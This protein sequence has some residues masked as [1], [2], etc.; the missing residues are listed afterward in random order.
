MVRMIRL[1]PESTI[2]VGGEPVTPTPAAPSCSRSYTICSGDTLFGISQLFGVSV[3]ALRAANEIT[4][5]LIYPGT[6]LCI[7]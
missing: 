7:P 2:V 5:N 4:G 1:S 6:V 3:D